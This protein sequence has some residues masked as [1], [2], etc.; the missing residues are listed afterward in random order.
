MNK[1]LAAGGQG[2]IADTTMTFVRDSNFVMPET[3]DVP[4]IMVGPGTGVVP[5]LGFMQE[6]EKA[7]ADSGAALG[8]A[9]LYFGCS[10]HDND[11]IYRDEMHAMKD[12]NVITSLN[13]AFSRPSEAGASKTYVQDLLAKNVEQIKQTLLE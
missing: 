10:Q 11:F 4:I 3:N 1:Y 9:H 8:T 13:M 5:F 6:R 2:E 7:Q 12:K